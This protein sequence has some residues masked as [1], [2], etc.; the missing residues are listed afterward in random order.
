MSPWEWSGGGEQGTS[1]AARLGGQSRGCPA[2]SGCLRGVFPASQALLLGGA[3][4]ARPAPF[5]QS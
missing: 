4:D 3:W 2:S 5:M 1:H